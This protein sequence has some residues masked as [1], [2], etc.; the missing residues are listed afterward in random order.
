[1]KKK[2]LYILQITI[3]LFAAHYV[4]AQNSFSEQWQHMQ[5]E[6]NRVLQTLKDQGLDALEQ[7]YVHPYW[8]ATKE[9][10]QKFI[11][12]APEKNFLS[13]W[14]IGYNMVRRQ[15]GAAQTY[16][17]CY[18][19][20][21]INK[22]TQNLLASFK[23]SE[24]GQ[25][26]VDCYQYN[27]SSNTL[28]HLFYTAKVLENKKDKVIKNIVE[29]G[30]G[31]G[32]LAHIFKTIMPQTTLFLIDLPEIL[33]IQMLFLRLSMPDT[34]VYWHAQINQTYQENAIHLI[35]VHLIDQLTLNA[36][37]FISTFAL[38]ES[39]ELIQELVIKKNFFNASMLYITGQIDGWGK[40][41]FVS[42]TLLIDAIR[43]SYQAVECQPMHLILADRVS[44]EIIGTK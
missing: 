24:V 41:N 6:Y 22:K 7:S 15:M 35:P 5:N 11:L 1:M 33:A 2:N 9:E 26:D 40:L 36:D 14:Q 37:L 27:C 42:H 13:G 12:G 25:L 20:H 19:E 28:G 23:E 3:S 16:E 34:P 8:Q 21:C 17:I 29:F 10:I 43:N 38:S 39:T 30:S 32:N 44:Y 4:S 18:L 31:Y